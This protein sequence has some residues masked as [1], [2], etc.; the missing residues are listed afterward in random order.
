MTFMVGWLAIS[1]V[2]PFAGFWSKDEILAGAWL[3]NK[4]LWAI[5]LLTAL[6]TAYY[7]SRQ[8]FLVFY[9]EDRWKEADDGHEVHPPHESPWVMTTPLVILA[10]LA[11]IG[12]LLNLPFASSLQFLSHWL[13]PSFGG[14]YHHHEFTGYTQWFLAL[15]ATAAAGIGIFAAY[16]TWYRRR[17]AEL[18]NLEPEPMKRA[19]YVDAG[20]S[21]FFGGPGRWVADKAAFV[22]DK[23]AIDGAVNGVAALV[24][25]SGSQLRKVQTGF[26]RN[27]ALGVAAGA[28]LLLAY[29]FARGEL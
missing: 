11:A 26:V 4:L 18:A 16:S 8:V 1:G 5:G 23:G 28:V 27:Y 17:P 2:P 14:A 10:V 29:A 19:W 20:F 6:L 15:A 21:A 3:D 13:E 22:V 24:R 9:G 7:M 25:N 12:G